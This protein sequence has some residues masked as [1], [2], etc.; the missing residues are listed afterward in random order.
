MSAL[1]RVTGLFRNSPLQSSRYVGIRN[2]SM[3]VDDNVSGITDE[4]KQVG[5]PTILQ[6]SL[7]DFYQTVYSCSGVPVHSFDFFYL[8]RVHL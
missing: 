1:R 5:F 4:Q 6:Q 2:L 7:A 8:A 3:T